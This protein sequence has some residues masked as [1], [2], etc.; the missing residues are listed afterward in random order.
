MKTRFTILLT[1]FVL[2]SAAGIVI[3]QTAQTAVLS[4]VVTDE[5]KAIIPG[6][7]LRLFNGKSIIRDAVSSEDGSFSL[8]ELPFGTYKLSVRKEG[9]ADREVTIE[10][11]GE[12][13]GSEV[14]LSAGG[15]TESVTVVLDSAEWCRR[16]HGE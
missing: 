3:G 12:V 7:S 14:V 11:D 9:F 15:V 6:A 8:G 5:A 13:K 10:L 4:G 2:L 16:Q 1:A